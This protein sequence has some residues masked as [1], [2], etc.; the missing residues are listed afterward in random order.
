MNTSDSELII[1]Y[2]T[3]GL[4]NLIKSVRYSVNEKD[5]SI[6]KHYANNYLPILFN[7]FEKFHGSWDDENVTIPTTGV[8]RNGN[9]EYVKV[10]GETIQNY[11]KICDYSY[12]CSLYNQCLLNL[13]NA[14]TASESNIQNTKTMVIMS[15]LLS[16]FIDSLESKEY[17][18]LFNSLKPL[19][20]IQC[21]PLQRRLYNIL[22]AICKLKTDFLTDINNKK[23]LCE[24]L[25]ENINN[26]HATSKKM[27]LRCISMVIKSLVLSSDEMQY[28]PKLL[29]E[30]L[31]SLKDTNTKYIT[32][33]III[34]IE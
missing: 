18:L 28:I 10:I 26:L 8:S 4:L 5:L 33:I 9:M 29:P 21:I 24:I 31:A 23:V 32:F 11:L 17:L 25:I 2:I 27:H 7:L 22:Y 16:Y 1:I 14:S 12:I 30:I 34:I 13:V 6:I 15:G 20:T 3:K 19:F